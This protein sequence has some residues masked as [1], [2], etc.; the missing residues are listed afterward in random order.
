MTLIQR[1]NDRIPQCDRLTDRIFERSNI[2]SIEYLN[3]QTMHPIEWF[4]AGIWLRAR[5][6]RPYG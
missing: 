2:W 4:V 1:L 5:D 3:G 6:A